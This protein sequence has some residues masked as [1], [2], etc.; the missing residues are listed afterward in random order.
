MYGKILDYSLLVFMEPVEELTM[1]A[2][3]E[4]QGVIMTAMT[5]AACVAFLFYFFPSFFVNIFGSGNNEEYAVILPLAR[6]LMHILAFA[7]LLDGTGIVFADALRGAGDTLF[8]MVSTV[9]MA[10]FIYM[11]LVWFSVYRLHSVVTAWWVYCG[12]IAVYFI[13]FM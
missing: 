9:V 7:I 1:D 8:Q 13:C 3:S 11:P 4:Y 5:Y 2:P 10:V 6:R 12:Y